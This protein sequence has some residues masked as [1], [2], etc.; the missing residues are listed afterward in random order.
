MHVS[1]SSTGFDFVLLVSFAGTWNTKVQKSKE[2]RGT[3]P[4]FLLRVKKE[5][6]A[7]FP[8]QIRTPCDE[9]VLLVIMEITNSGRKTTY[10]CV[11][12]HLMAITSIGPSTA[13]KVDRGMGF[14]MF[15]PPVRV[16]K[17]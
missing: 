10:S 8:R 12:L 17:A 15:R 6:L 9:L 1:T 7:Y 2:M 5:S 13:K 11:G 14:S 3:N 16:K 4:G